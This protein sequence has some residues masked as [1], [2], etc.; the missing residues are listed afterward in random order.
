MTLAL[1][2]FVACACRQSLPERGL[3]SVKDPV[4]YDGK[5][6]GLIGKVLIRG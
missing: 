1:D 6:T 3:D 5:G 2:E 4:Q